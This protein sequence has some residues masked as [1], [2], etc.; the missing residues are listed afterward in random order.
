MMVVGRY[1]YMHE[2][3]FSKRRKQCQKNKEKK[4]FCFC[5]LP[6]K[7]DTAVAMSKS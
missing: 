6:F 2:K 7:K 3:D 5:F 4:H 1:I